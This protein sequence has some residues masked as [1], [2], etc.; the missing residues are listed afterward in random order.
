MLTE[1]EK[2]IACVD[3]QC[4]NAIADWHDTQ[5]SM[6]DAMGFDEAA[7]KHRFRAVQLREEAKRREVELEG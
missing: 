3:P 2:A 5:E 7:E 1:F 6:G 4:L